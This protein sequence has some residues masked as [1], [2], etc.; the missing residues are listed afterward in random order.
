MSA[1]LF[2]A[3]SCCTV[4]S[5]LTCCGEDDSYSSY[6]DEHDGFG[7]GI[8]SPILKIGTCD[9]DVNL[10]RCGRGSRAATCTG[11][12]GEASKRSTCTG[13]GGGR[14]SR[15]A[16]GRQPAQ[17]REGGYRGSRAAEGGQQREASREGWVH[18]ML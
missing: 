3:T 15:A 8:R 10:H 18:E 6:G 5:D 11:A 17:V 7:S 12:G 2:A 4:R 13:A 16:E 1:A 9:W 14:G